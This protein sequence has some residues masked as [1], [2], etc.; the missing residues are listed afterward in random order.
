MQMHQKIQKDFKTC[1]SASWVWFCHASNENL[2]TG[3]FKITKT[4]IYEYIRIY[5][6]KNIYCHTGV[7]MAGGITTS[8]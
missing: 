7:F 2:K 8:F 5:M 3:S 4:E 1:P 6:D